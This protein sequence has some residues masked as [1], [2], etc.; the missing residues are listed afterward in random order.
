MD[1]MPQE[2]RVVFFGLMG[3]D[4]QGGSDVLAAITWIVPALALM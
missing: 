1:T 3:G 4:L 2:K